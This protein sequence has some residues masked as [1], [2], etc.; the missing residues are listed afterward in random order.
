MSLNSNKLNG[1]IPP[2][3]GNLANLENLNVVNNRLSG[4]IPSQLG[5]LTNLYDVH[6]SRNQLSGCIPEAWRDIPESD[7]SSVGLEFCR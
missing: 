2:E 3:Q 4:A 1:P 7:L 5:N 6:L